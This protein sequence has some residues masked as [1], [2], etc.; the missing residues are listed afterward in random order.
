MS[1]YTTQVRYICEVAA[2]TD[3]YA[4][5]SIDD[6]I[7][8]AAPKIFNFN[9]PIF[10]EA[11]RLPLEKK[12]LR[13]YYTR[14]ISEETVALWKLR[15]N[16]KLNLI[17]PYYNKLYETTLLKFDPL[18]DTD[19]TTITDRNGEV[20]QAGSASGRLNKSTIDSR[21]D[22]ES[23]GENEA[24]SY[25][26][27]NEYNKEDNKNETNQNVNTGFADETESREGSNESDGNYEKWN[28]YS[29]TPQGG[30]A[31]IIGEGSS[32]PTVENNY[33]L[34]NVTQDTDTHHEEGSETAT[35][36]KATSTNNV[37]NGSYKTNNIETGDNSEIGT[38]NRN[39]INERSG[40]S[41][42]FSNETSSHNTNDA[43]KISSTEDYVE[44]IFGK[45]NGMTYSKMVQEFR[46]IIINIDAMIIDE[47][48]VLFFGLWA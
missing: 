39:R 47:L 25:N 1:N 35:S 6:L 9:F 4:Y 23:L 28:K 22:S 5:A 41:N 36:E 11:Y 8:Q 43:R 16:D 34:T 33:Y 2:E 20:N 19:I 7:T 40:N 24:N 18:K 17:M 3:Q 14:E 27:I 45:R 44:R 37:Q 48:N 12:I 13:H 42:G 15:L 30:I 29:D 21:E 31:G 32:D 38:S 26:K 10:D 46:E